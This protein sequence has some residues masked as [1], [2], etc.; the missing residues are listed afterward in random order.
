MNYLAHCLVADE[1]T[2]HHFP[3]LVAGGFLGDFIKGPLPS[4]LPEALALGVRLHRRIDAF[5]NELPGITTSCRRFPAPLRRLAPPFV[6][7]IA[8][9]FL[10]RDWARFCPEPL[11]AFSARIYADIAERRHWMPR[12]G[13]RFFAYMCDEDLLCGYRDRRVMYRGLVS[14]TRRLGRED[15][16]DELAASLEPLM[17]DL[18]ADFVDYFPALIEH[19][20]GWVADRINVEPRSS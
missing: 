3:D 20:R 10:A 19:A 5:S 16:N 7:V 9:H 2:D 13:A 8:D 14:I 11:E 17:A 15:L 12:G 18:R 1:A 4:T 6:D